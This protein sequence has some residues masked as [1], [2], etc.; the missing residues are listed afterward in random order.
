MN[1]VGWTLRNVLNLKVFLLQQ[2]DLTLVALVLVV[3]W[4]LQVQ[5][6]LLEEEV[7]SE[8]TQRNLDCLDLLR[9]FDLRLGGP[10]RLKGSRRV[11]GRES[12][13]SVH[14][15]KVTRSDLWDREVYDGIV[16]MKPFGQTLQ[17]NPLISSLVEESSRSSPLLSLRKGGLLLVESSGLCDELERLGDVLELKDLLQAQKLRKLDNQVEMQS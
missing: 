7:E 9:H 1:S 5:V 14:T 10:G 12:E 17:R 8:R 4:C 2:K 3:T 16:I 11:L 15:E 6:D 13:V